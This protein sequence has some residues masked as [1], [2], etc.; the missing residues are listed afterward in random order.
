MNRRRQAI[1]LALGLVGVGL[2]VA[3]VVIPGRFA[4]AVAEGE[5][6][7]QDVPEPV[8]VGAA[9]LVLLALWI[10]AM[11]L[12]GRILYWGWKQIDDYVFWIWDLVL[13]ESPLVRFAVGLTL[14]MAFFVLGP[15]VVLQALDV[16]NDED[17]I[18]ED[19]DDGPGDGDNQT[20]DNATADDGT[21]DNETATGGAN[22]TAS[23][24]TDWVGSTTVH[25][26]R[27]GDA[28]EAT[29]GL[30]ATARQSGGA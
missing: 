4:T 5:R 15:L 17:P 22:E 11:I 13:P 21:V 26:W 9:V 2:A 3:R 1:V 24:A 25:R 27:P 18:E 30:A 8:L 29:G 28:G 10:A 23:L 14:M 16:S 12:L 7:L 20:A 19:G 6:L